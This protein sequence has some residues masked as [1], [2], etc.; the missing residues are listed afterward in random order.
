MD[1]A[2]QDPQQPTIQQAVS[3]QGT[4]LEEHKHHIQALVNENRMLASQVATLTT[5]LAALTPQLHAASATASAPSPNPGSESR[6][7]L[8][9]ASPSSFSGEPPLCNGFIFQC[10]RFF[11]MKPVSFTSD[12]ARVNFMLGLLSGRALA[13]AEARFAHRSLEGMTYTEFLEQFRQVFGPPASP[14]R[15]SSRLMEMHQGRQP[16]ADYVLEFRT[17]A[18]EVDWSDSSLCAAFRKGLREQLKDELAYRE[19]PVNLD[20]LISLAINIDSRL[21]AR[22]LERQ[23]VSPL[24]RSSREASHAQVAASDAPSLSTRSELEEPMQVGRTRLTPGERNRRLREGECLY[25]GQ[26]GHFLSN[27]SVRPKDRARQ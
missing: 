8:P 20:A 1:P 16:L 19:D 15:T 24:P 6:Q 26:T 5:Q 14:F 11:Q 3:W 7:D 27:C 2:D 25:C 21:Q 13:W 23:A 18:A 10:E 9:A 4:M 22:R 12:R 17:L